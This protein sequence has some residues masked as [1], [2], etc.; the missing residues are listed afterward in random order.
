MYP[1]SRTERPLLALLALWLGGCEGLWVDAGDL[2][3]P[4]RT[5]LYADADEDGRGDATHPLGCAVP[6]AQAYATTGDDCDDDDATVHPDADEIPGDGVDS[7][8][9]GEDDT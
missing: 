9:D 8:C 6:E 4:G 5:R 3:P 2:C 7:N 1:R